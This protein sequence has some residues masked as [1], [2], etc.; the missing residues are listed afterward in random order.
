MPTAIIA[1]D[2]EFLADYLKQRLAALW[3]ELQVVGVAANGVEALDF[4]L[5]RKPDIAFL[6]IRMPG[7]T[8]LE[9]AQQLDSR[10]RVV[11]VTAYDQYAVDAFESAAIDY[12]LK[13]VE[14]DRLRRTIERL[15]KQES[16]LIGD[17]LGKIESLFGGG[18]REQLR[19]IRAAVG[20]SVRLIDVNDVCYFEAQDKYTQVATPD[21]EVLIRTPIKD[22][23]EQLDPNRFWQIHRGTIVAVGEIANTGQDFRGRMII[24]LKRRKDTLVVSRAYT[25]LF[26]Q[27]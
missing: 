19:W 9:V 5:A 4:A 2:E 14:D 12:L 21:G 16:P 27:M 23:V 18:G 7:M 26:K 6:D 20:T 8:G 25:H 15:N 1:D 11:F 3:P 10:I 13:P 24:K 17:V 22:L